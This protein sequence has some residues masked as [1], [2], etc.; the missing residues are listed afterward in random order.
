MLG[1]SAPP[2]GSCFSRRVDGRDAHAGAEP[3]GQAERAKRGRVRRAS[4]RIRPRQA[5]ARGRQRADR[6]LRRVVLAPR[7]V[8]AAAAGRGDREPRPV[9]SVRRRPLRRA[10]GE[11]R[12]GRRRRPDH[13]HGDDHERRPARRARRRPRRARAAGKPVRHRRVDVAARGLRAEGLVRDVLVRQHPRAR[14]GDRGL[15]GRRE[16]GSARC[17]PPRSSA[18]AAASAP[19]A[20]T[21]RCTTR[22]SRTTAPARSRR[23][24][25]SRR[26]ESRPRRRCRFRST[27]GSTAAIA[28]RTTR[29]PAFPPPPPDFDCADLSFRGFQVLHDPTPRTPDPHSF[30]NNFDGV[31]C[32]F[33][34]Y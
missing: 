27:T 18:S 23:S 30:D 12:G 25:R 31:G 9:G 17:P 10:D 34:D 32:Q 15:H 26:P 33:D 11:A 19:R 8:R 13:V 1:I 5:V 4:G 29:R 21:G 20:A 7:F 14:D 24:S 22:T 28:I 16:E 6:R 2:R 3:D